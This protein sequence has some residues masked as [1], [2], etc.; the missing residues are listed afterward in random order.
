MFQYV[1]LSLLFFAVFIGCRSNI[2]SFVL[3]YALF[4][5]LNNRNPMKMK[6]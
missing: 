5:H 1:V 2:V 4:F 6:V 3:V